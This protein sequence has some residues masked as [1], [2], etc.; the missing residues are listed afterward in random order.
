[1]QFHRYFL[2]L[3]IVALGAFLRLQHLDADL[4]HDEIYTWQVFASQSYQEIVT[5]YFVPNNHIL[6]TLAVRLIAQCLGHD[7]ITLRLPAFFAGILALPAI[8]LLTRT[9]FNSTLAGFFAMFLLALAPSHIDYS[10]QA[11]G[12]SM[13]LL[14]SVLHLLG[15]WWS[16]RRH[17]LW[18]GL[19]I[20]SGFLAIYTIPSAVYH[21][22]PLNLWLLL[23]SWQ[24]KNYRQSLKTLL[25]GL[26]IFILA[27][28]AYAPVL[29]ELAAASQHWGILLNGDLGILAGVVYDTIALCSGGWAGLLPG[30]AALV[31]VIMM[32]RHRH[33]FAHYVLLVWS[34]PF[35][36]NFITGIAGQPRTYFF[37]LLSLLISTSYA[38]IKI[39]SIRMQILSL[40]VLVTG[41]GWTAGQSLLTPVNH[42]FKD[43]DRQLEQKV[44]DG[45][46]LI[47][48]FILDTEISYV[49]AQTIRQ[50][51][52]TTLAKSELRHLLFA[53]RPD[54][55][56]FQ[57]G[58]YLMRRNF[59]AADGAYQDH[60]HFPANSFQAI[61]QTG[62]LE[63]HRL[64]GLG[65]LKARPDS[66]KIAYLIDKA[67]IHLQAGSP[68]LGELPSLRI[69]NPKG[70]RV[71]LQAD[72]LFTVPA[73]GLIAL[74]YAR[75]EPNRTT[76]SLFQ[77]TQKNSG[78]N[79]K[80]LHMYRTNS[81]VGFADERGQY[82]YLETYIRPVERDQTYGIYLITWEVADQYIAD[83]HCFFLAY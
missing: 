69:D 75:T 71:T 33:P 45:E 63:I 77:L 12:Y 15:A 53:S 36:I 67:P 11:R 16:L 59:V 32:L 48:P 61:H 50:G 1:M 35:L 23:V 66:W 49:A 13:L 83:L 17:P 58:H 62:P 44:S 68:L 18:W 8:Y 74:A 9:I 65:Q 25:A 31:G 79:K 29:S 82:W 37:L 14:F 5:S 46:I 24:D 70:I 52:I 42:A 78:L 40:A 73:D 43:L 64:L 28:L 2:L 72:N 4:S 81:P 56:R 41:Y 76:A 47:A 10:H 39:A 30:M 6:H 26:V 19:Y 34:V 55:Q 51:I 27:L 60:L 54:Q 3:G 21:V 22:I 38:L 20:F 7:A 80:P 57:L